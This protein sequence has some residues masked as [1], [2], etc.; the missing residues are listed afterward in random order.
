VPSLP[1]GSLRGGLARASS[2]DR[3]SSVRAGHQFLEPGGSNRSG[4]SG[5]AA[6]L[7]LKA[8]QRAVVHSGSTY[9][10]SE[11]VRTALRL[12]SPD[13]KPIPIGVA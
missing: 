5:I 11:L 3:E 1:E 13:P 10:L 4:R 8:K 6:A 12:P 2:Y 9:S 7:A